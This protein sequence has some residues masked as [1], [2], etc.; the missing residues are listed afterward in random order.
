MQRKIKILLA[1]GVT[2]FF[3]LA[4][5]VVPFKKSLLQDP[6]SWMT[7]Q[8]TE[9]LAVFSHNSLDERELEKFFLDTPSER[10]LVYVSIKKGT[11][12]FTHGPCSGRGTR[13]KCIKKFLLHLARHYTLPDTSFIVSLEDAADDHRRPIPLFVF[14]KDKKSLYN[15]LFPDFEALRMDKKLSL[16]K[17]FCNL[18]P[19]EKKQA[20][21][22]WRG[23]D[24]GLP[25][26]ANDPFSFPR[27]SLVELSCKY[28]AWIDA[29]FVLFSQWNQE[30]QDQ[31]LA[32]TKPLANHV[33][34]QD[35]FQYKYLI[36]IDGN[37]CTY[38]RCRWILVSNSTL[39]KPDSSNIQ[40]Y[41]KALIPFVHYVPLAQ[42]LH[43]L[44]E[45]YAWLQDHD[46]EA[47]AIAD[48]GSLL[49]QHIFSPSMIDEY[50]V[51]LLSSYAKS[52]PQRQD[53]L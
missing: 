30:M 4:L 3:L 14:A 38:E 52:F 21:V 1:F 10:G 46:R 34:I 11:P 15:V 28:P 19:W 6:P 43:N 7:A 48:A 42:D 53:A 51:Q 24:T 31:V 22:F 23:A 41:Y 37:S 17:R 20:K 5:F 2:S 25:L 29:A 18:Y 47:K 36:D 44:K 26:F 9:D 12:T 39:L 33:P 13:L 45:V 35:H 32:R 27:L 49:G 40:W 8:I 16:W 50:V